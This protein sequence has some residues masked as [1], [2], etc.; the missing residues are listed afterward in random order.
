MTPDLKTF[1]QQLRTLR[2]QRGLTQSQLANTIHVSA[3]L[4]SLWERA[5]EH[6]GR[7]WLPD[8]QSVIRLV[9]TFAGFLTAEE[10][11]VWLNLVAYKLTEEE[12]QAIFSGYSAPSATPLPSPGGFR[13]NLARLE[14]PPEQR[15]FGVDAARRKLL[16]RLQA[17]HAPWLLAL[18]GIGG[19]GKTTLAAALA[20]DVMQAD[21]YHDLAW[22]SAKQEEFV[23]GAGLQAIDRPALNE[24]ILIDVLLEQLNSQIPLT[25][26]PEEKILA[27]TNLF[28][29]QRYLVIVD[30]LET[31]ADYQALL[32]LLRRLANPSKFLL[33]TRYS[34]YHE[35]DV[36]CFSLTELSQEDVLAFLSYEA[37][38]RGLPALANAPASQLR[39]IYTVVGGNPLAL[40]LVIGQLKFFPLS[41]V[42]DNLKQ[43]QGKRTEELYTYIYWQAWQSL[44]EA[45]QAVLLSMPLAQGGD[46]QQLK[47]L[48]GLENE[49]LHQ[50]IERLVGLSLLEISGDLEYHRYRIHRLTESFLL[51]EVTKWQ[52]PQ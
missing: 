2:K 36:Y 41:Q 5:Y 42:L 7:T 17:D 12:L 10:A 27:L 24:A 51:E 32:P 35:D 45:G 28:E 25:N 43:A 52:S 34:L 22:V 16:K 23:P 21:Q 8:R 47:A 39:Q 11:Q 6:Q 15:L 38:V 1:G 44:S 31:V 50:A 46:L 29:R 33:T 26:S 4:I 14:L 48:C 19:I 13:A 3:Q 30:N 20:A 49:A 9:E 18:D 40:K 37:E